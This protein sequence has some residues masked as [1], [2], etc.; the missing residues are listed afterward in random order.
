V[1]QERH[2]QHAACGAVQLDW[3]A[4][5]I[6]GLGQRLVRSEMTRS[7]PL[8]RAMLGVLVPLVRRASMI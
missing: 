6:F 4:G 8:P 2:E 7:G 5:A 1:Q 3:L